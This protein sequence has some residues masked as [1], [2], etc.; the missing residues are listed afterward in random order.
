MCVY[1]FSYVLPEERGLY[2]KNKLLDTIVYFAGLRGMTGVVAKQKALEWLRRFNIEDYAKRKVEE[3]SKGNQQKAQFITSILH[4]PEYIVLDE[5]FSG[6][7]PVNQIVLKDILQELKQQGKAIIFSTHQMDSAEKLCDEICLI[8]RG[9]IVLEGSMKEVKAKF[10]KNSVHVE[11]VGD[12]SFIPALPQVKKATV[13]ENYAE[14]ELNGTVSSRELLSSISSKVEI[15]KFEFVEPSLN[16]IFLDVVGLPEETGERVESAAAVL[17]V[18]TVAGDM[19]VRK[20]MLIFVF[21]A[22]ATLVLAILTLK[23]GEPSWNVSLVLL[24]TS[25]YSFVKYIRIRKVV[26]AELQLLGEEAAHGK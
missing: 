5:P 22:V 12:G 10:G 18:K 20:Q 3:L 21:A 14:L 1:S 4:D 26:T 11:F 23:K 16:S 24:V 19:R 15:R 7:D 9:K 8:N 25:V 17:K 2:K 6:L 13:Y